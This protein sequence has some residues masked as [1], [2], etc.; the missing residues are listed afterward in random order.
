MVTGGFRSRIGL[1]HAVKSG[2]CDLVG[3]GRPSVIEPKLPK[4]IIFNDKI[5]NEDA[6]L[7]T[8]SFTQSFVAHLLGVKGIGGGTETVSN[9]RIQ[10]YDWIQD[11]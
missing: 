7:K 10:S 11:N 9:S 1:E 6:R 4:T 8:K 5:S 2:A 3:L